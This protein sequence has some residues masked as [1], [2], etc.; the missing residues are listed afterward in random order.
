MHALDRSL[1]QGKRVMISHIAAQSTIQIGMQEIL[2][3]AVVRS[4][5]QGPIRDHSMCNCPHSSC[6]CVCVCV[7][8][9]VKVIALELIKGYREMAADV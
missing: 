5:E 7:C 4:S 8:E 1:A 3:T 2:F 6:V 9:Q